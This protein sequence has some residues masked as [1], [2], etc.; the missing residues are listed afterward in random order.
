MTFYTDMTA[1]ALALITE[2]GSDLT[3]RGADT[4]EDPV[5]GAGGG[6]GAER[7]AKG[8]L[9]KIDDKAFPET[10]IERGDRMMILEGA[11]NP[12]MGERWVD[13][14]NVWTF[15]GIVSIAPHNGSPVIHKVLVR[16]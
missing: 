3:I 13:G 14:A 16:G 12:V 9:T 7:T 1:E 15:E 4:P 2:F 5:T 11:A 8:V 10:R 6:T